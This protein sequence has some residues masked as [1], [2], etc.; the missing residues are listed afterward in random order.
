MADSRMTNNQDDESES[1]SASLA[2][3]LPPVEAL[4]LPDS[5]SAKPIPPAFLSPESDRSSP[6]DADSIGSLSTKSSEDIRALLR[7][8]DDDDDVSEP[9]YDDDASSGLVSSSTEDLRPQL[10]QSNTFQFFRPAAS[11]V[12]VF[13]LSPPLAMAGST[14]SI[15]SPKKTFED[16]IREASVY[17]G[18]E[19]YK[20][21]LNCYLRAAREFLDASAMFTINQML[22]LGKGCRAEPLSE[23]LLLARRYIQAACVY[24][25]DV[26]VLPVYLMQLEMTQ[27]AYLSSK[28][29][30]VDSAAHPSRGKTFDKLKQVGDKLVDFKKQIR[31]TGGDIAQRFLLVGGTFLSLYTIELEDG[32]CQQSNG[33]NELLCLACDYFEAA[34]HVAADL[35]SMMTLTEARPIE[36]DQRTNETKKLIAR[37]LGKTAAL[38]VKVAADENVRTDKTVII[39]LYKKLKIQPALPSP[40]AVARFSRR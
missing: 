19:Q 27:H 1:L 3:F 37:H 21:A 7:A 14:V 13:G 2:A 35:D 9:A 6:C 23:R 17:Y 31:E 5:A 11:Q 18:N 22:W 29:A 10:F 36:K 26:D 16:R 25:D 4:S 24:C 33:A 38:L 15:R 20:H 39:E 30:T 12:P 40:A 8:D 28:H 34:S 32:P